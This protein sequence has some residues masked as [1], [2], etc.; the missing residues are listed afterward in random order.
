MHVL[1][2]QAGGE[3]KAFIVIAYHKG[4]YWA[5]AG[6]PALQAR[7]FYLLPEVGYNTM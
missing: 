7:Y 5:G 4:L 2:L 6:Y 1:L 3:G